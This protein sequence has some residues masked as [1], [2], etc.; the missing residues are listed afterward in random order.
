MGVH[1]Q[2]HQSFSQ[3]GEDLA[4]AAIFDLVG[5]TRRPH[6]LEFGAGDGYTGSNARAFQVHCGW[7]LIQWEKDSGY[8]WTPERI[9]LPER[10]WREHVTRDNVSHLFD[11]YAVPC[12]LDLLSIDVDGNDYWIWSELDAAYQ[13][14]VV[15]IEF[16]ANF[17]R[18]VHKA[19][20]YHPY[21]AWAGDVAFGA[22]F[23]AMC[24]LGQ[25]KGYVAVRVV[26]HNLIFVRED[27]YRPMD[28][29]PGHAPRDYDLP[30]HCHRQE[31]YDRFVDV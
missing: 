23:D 28:D 12:E 31:G 17:P 9:N 13:P 3:H 7:Q 19:L 15:V 30:H 27:L 1:I 21:N 10:V 4:I 24:A 6:A 29:I 25:S 2:A 18:G 8:E 16:N 22:S 20:R 5:T 26:G 14:R 11:I